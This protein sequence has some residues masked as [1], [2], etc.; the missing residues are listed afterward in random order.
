MLISVVYFHELKIHIYF[1]YIFRSRNPF[2]LFVK[3]KRTKKEYSDE[4]LLRKWNNLEKAVHKEYKKKLKEMKNNY[5]N[6]YTVFVSRLSKKDLKK[7]M[8]LKN[9]V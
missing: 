6:E 4:K 7:F 9:P 8:A 1:E 3:E 2:D 5:L